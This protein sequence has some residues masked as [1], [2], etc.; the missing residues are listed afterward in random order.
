MSRQRNL[1]DLLDSNGD[2]KSSALDNVPASNNASALTTGTLPDARLSNQVR[3][4]KSSSAPG[5]PQEGDLWYDTSEEELK[6]YNSTDSAFVKIAKIIPTLTSISG[7][8]TNAT[9][10]NLTLTGSG[11]LSSNLIVSFTP[12][13][14]SATNV[15]VTP[16]NDATATV[17]IPSGIYGQAIG[18]VIAI[19]VTNTDGKVSNIVNKTVVTGPY[20]INFLVIAGGG[21][22][23]HSYGG[24]GGAGGYRASFNSETSG[25]G[26]SS[27][28]EL[29]NISTGTVFTVT[30]GAGGSRATYGNLA[31]SGSNSSIAGS[32]ITTITSTGG[33]GAGGNLTNGAAGGSGGG[34][35]SGGSGGAGTANQGF[36]AGGAPSNSSGYSAGGGGG[37]GSAGSSPSTNANNG[38]N[39]GNGTASTI[40][41]SSVIRAGGGGGSG[42]LGTGGSGGSGGGGGGGDHDGSPGGSNGTQNTGSGGGGGG[43]T[44]YGDGGSGVVILRVPT[45][46]YSGTTS[47][48]PGVSNSGSDTILTF[49]ASGSYTS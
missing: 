4:I 34:G 39:G 25:G 26:G 11:F 12:S 17:A 6:V 32:G 5:S 19:K 14:G 23:G 28:T 29:Q 38:A 1:S 33:G 37:S 49:N 15:T 43:G 42:Y 21:G 16:S 24:G 27:E 47:G 35:G 22:G 30:V 13:G 2:V 20:A 44:G 45:V 10:G 40:S 3:V 31:A 8:I 7:D 9:A 48:S 46:S 36:A 41:G 18:T